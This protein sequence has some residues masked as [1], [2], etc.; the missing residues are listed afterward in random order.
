MNSDA[1]RLWAPWRMEF[2]LSQKTTGC[3][4]CECYETQQPSAEFVLYRNKYGLIMLNRYPYING[5][6]LVAPSSH[7]SLPT[8]LNESEYYGF[9]DLLLLGI[10]SIKDSLN[11]DGIN[12]GM[13][14][15][16]AAGAGVEDHIHYHIVPRWFGDNNAMAVIGGAR[17]I[18]EALEKTFEKLAHWFSRPTKD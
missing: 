14:L 17:V 7:V 13:N 15:G 8:Q 9:H 2:I 6:L 5:H 12:V 10:R 18:S 1:Q 4:L 11:S 16:K 3:F